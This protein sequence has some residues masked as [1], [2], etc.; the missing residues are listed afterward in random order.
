M[1]IL[2]LELKLNDYH[3][4]NIKEH[5]CDEMPWMLKDKFYKL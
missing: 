1:M 5:L 2:I 4:E 3:G